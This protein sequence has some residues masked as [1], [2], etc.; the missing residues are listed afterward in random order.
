MILIT[1][2]VINGLILYVESNVNERLS[3]YL[4]IEHTLFSFGLGE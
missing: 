4:S 2:I 3:I 1:L